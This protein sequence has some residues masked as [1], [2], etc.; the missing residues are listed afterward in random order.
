MNIIL[1]DNEIKDILRLWIEKTYSIEI[2]TDIIET[3]LVQTTPAEIS[4]EFK[5]KNNQ[6]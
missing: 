2:N 1:N 3:H 5:T 6:N 4:I